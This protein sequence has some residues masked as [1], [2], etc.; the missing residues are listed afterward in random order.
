MQPVTVE[1]KYKEF[2]KYIAREMEVFYKLEHHGFPKTK[3]AKRILKSRTS[4]KSAMLLLSTQEAARSCGQ[5]KLRY[6]GRR[7]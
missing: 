3:A 2:H 6:V 5:Q 4:L 1:Y 7:R